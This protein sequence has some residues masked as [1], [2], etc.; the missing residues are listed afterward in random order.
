[1]FISL[2]EK[3]RCN[4]WEK[5]RWEKG[6]NV[7]IGTNNHLCVP[8]CHVT[9]QVFYY[10]GPSWRVGQCSCLGWYGPHGWAGS[11][12]TPPEQMQA[13]YS[14]PVAEASTCGGSIN[15]STSV[16]QC[17][18]CI[19][20]VSEG[21]KVWIYWS[22]YFFSSETSIFVPNLICLKGPFCLLVTLVRGKEKSD[23][24]IQ[25]KKNPLNQ[26]STG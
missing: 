2:H 13:A 8:K 17:I 4:K 14:A 11:L 15:V 12:Q 16:L 9:N 19:I 23:K 18:L 26:N 22:T 25:Q 5:S 3:F 24:D 20:Q 7:E 1:M 10:Q 6:I 21:F